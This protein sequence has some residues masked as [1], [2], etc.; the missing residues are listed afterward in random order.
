MAINKL[1]EA[2]QLKEKDPVILQELEL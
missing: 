1:F 2:H